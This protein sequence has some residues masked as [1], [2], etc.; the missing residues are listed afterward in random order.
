MNKILA[1]LCLPAIMML[2]S[3]VA[4]AQ[5]PF[6]STFKGAERAEKAEKL[7][8][9]Y[10]VDANK[11]ITI[12]RTIEGLNMDAQTAIKTAHE[13]LDEAYQICKFSIDVVN[14]E[15]C[16]V[17]AKSSLDHFE[18]YAIYPNDYTFNAPITM[19]FDAKE[20]RLRMMVILTT[21]EGIRIN[22][23]IYDPFS[24]TIADVP[25]VNENSTEKKK[26]HIK[27]F[28]SLYNRVQDLFDE[29][30]AYIQNRNG[31][32]VDEDW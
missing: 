31:V 23:N 25:P 8:G 21:Y 4:Y 27:A 30:E 2:L 28:L 32:Q 24:T 5:G 29:A 9:K 6:D 13:Y 12:V 3:T 18:T 22:G 7:K 10:K 1:K 26:M 14:E 11:N 15:D 20:G 16:F 17:I 19:R